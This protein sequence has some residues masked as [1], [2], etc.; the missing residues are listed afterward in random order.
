MQLHNAAM[1]AVNESIYKARSL[2]LANHAPCQG[3]I[4]T[5]YPG[6]WLAHFLVPSTVLKRL[7]LLLCYAITTNYAGPSI[8]FYSGGT[9][10]STEVKVH[11][12]YCRDIGTYSFALKRP[13]SRSRYSWGHPATTALLTKTSSAFKLTGIALQTQVIWGTGTFVPLS[14]P[15][16][17]PFYLANLLVLLFVYVG[18]L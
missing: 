13:G 4:R 14:V 16:F 15:G 3:K 18:A 11:E 5:N 12:G 10:T 8:L 17:A 6:D 2:P 1:L 9:N 7:G